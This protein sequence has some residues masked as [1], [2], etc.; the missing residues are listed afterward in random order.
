MTALMF[1]AVVVIG[2]MLGSIPFGVFI[3]KRFANKDVREVGS[4]KIGMTNVLRTAGKKAAAL[5]LVLDIGKGALAVAIAGLIFHDK[6]AARQRHIYAGT[7]APRY[8]RR[9]RRSPGIAGR[10]SLNSKGGGGWRH[11]WAGWR[12]CT[13]RRPYSAGY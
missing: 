8:W 13:G 11:S 10:Y 5:S 7:K 4:G 9:W 2:Y 12:P 1:I 3:S 6:T